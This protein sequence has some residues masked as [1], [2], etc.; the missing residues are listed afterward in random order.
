[1]THLMTNDTYGNDIFYK[2]DI[3]GEQKV[4]KRFSH[5]PSLHAVCRIALKTTPLDFSDHVLSCN[6]IEYVKNIPKIVF[7]AYNRKIVSN[8]AIILKFP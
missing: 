2:C 1:M 8:E 6:V 3:Q 4:R 5:C 7:L